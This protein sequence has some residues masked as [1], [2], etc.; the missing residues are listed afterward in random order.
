MRFLVLFLFVLIS[1][2]HAL[3]MSVPQSHAANLS[4]ASITISTSRP[5]P[6]SPLDT[7]VSAGAGQ[8][9]IFS[10]SSRFLASDSAKLIRTGT[11]EIITTNIPV[12]SQSADLSAVYLNGTVGAAAGAGADVLFTPITAMHTVSFRA[13]TTIP[14][15]GTID[16]TYPGSGNN[17]ASPSATTFAFNN[18][19][20]SNIRANFSAGSATCTF[21]INAPTITCTVGTDSVTAGTTVTLLIGCSA[22]SGTSCTTQSPTLINPTK[23]NSTPGASDVWRV[24]LRTTDGGT[25]LDSA[26]LSIGTIESVTVRAN[27]DPSLSFTIA[28]I[29][30]GLQVNDGNA[31]GCSQND[32]TSTGINSS[33]TEI[34]LGTLGNSPTATNTRVS[35]IAAQLITISTNAANGYVLTATS[36]GHLRNPSTGYFF[37]DA[38]VPQAFPSNGANFFGF[39]ACGLDTYNASVGTTFWNTTASDTACN[40]YH[41]GSSGNLCKYGWPTT[42]TPITIAYDSAGPIG[43]TVETGN[44]LVSM[45]YA[46]GADATVPPGQY[47]TVVTYVATPTF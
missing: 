4:P 7:N 40:T 30:N 42:T 11:S 3:L 38:T 9:S 13:V 34:N 26:A 36:S 46:A 28:G 39:H 5:S 17:T 27:V 37:N 16:I 19:A 14:V 12:A 33:A 23:G 35:N 22:N 25:E 47:T 2:W 24:S 8:L 41:S 15:G 32:F 20:G 29:N 10:N 44:G 18:L 21:T 1:G 43:N 6:S 31:T 45:S